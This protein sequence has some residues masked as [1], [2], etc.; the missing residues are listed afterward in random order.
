MSKK[1]SDKD[2]RDWE[3]FVNSKDRISSKEEIKKGHVNKKG[4]T[5]K[6]DLHGFSLDQ[7]NKFIEK[8]INDCFEKEVLKLN[9]ITGK[10]LRSK[11]DKNPYQS[12][13][14]GILKYSVPEFI[15]TN[16]DLMKIIKKI[17]TTDEK[18]SGSF[19]VYLK[20]KNKFR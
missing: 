9:I 4:S 7:A 6:I 15:K 14:L 13:N 18:N 17:E 11:V 12:K 2:L 16:T 8:T 19:N 10:G 1:L 3:N 5:F 20:S